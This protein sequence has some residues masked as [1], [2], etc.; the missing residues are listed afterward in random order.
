MNDTT[1]L[2]IRDL[3]QRYN[4]VFML[5]AYNLVFKYFYAHK[6]LS[7]TTQDGKKFLT[8]HLY[9]FTNN[10]LWVREKFPDCA[11][12]VC[13]D[14][15]D[16]DRKSLYPEYKAHREH[17]IEPADD[18]PVLKMFS[19]LVDGVYWCHNENAEADDISASIT[20]TIKHLC[21]KFGIGKQIYLLS[22]DKDWW[23]LIDD[24]DGKHCKVATVKK[25]GLGDKWL[26]DAVI[27]HEK[28]VSEE[29]NGVSPENL[30]K[31]R[32]ITGDSSDNIKGYYRFFKKNAAIIAENFDYN[33]DTKILSL[34]PGVDMRA[35]WHKFLHT[36]T[37]DMKPFVRNYELMTL[38]E[39]DFELE[40]IF[41]NLT[42][43]DIEKIVNGLSVLKL[44][45][46]MYKVPNFSRYK[47]TI[48]KYTDEDDEAQEAPQAGT[49]EADL[50]DLL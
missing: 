6:D 26:E 22:S 36:I 3:C 10:F 33:Q 28:E 18:I 30:L 35:S 44:Q 9:G 16:K 24:G 5:D 19:S 49:F 50:N 25:W 40:P 31:F 43:S 47:D 20:R 11:F 14:G 29:F 12:V 38:K 37:D 23:Q 2:A 4:P 32:A 7:V 8:G 17:E 1:K 21:N 41:E 46:F 27:I 15:E 45:S 48:K 39:V 34:K 13:V 42:E